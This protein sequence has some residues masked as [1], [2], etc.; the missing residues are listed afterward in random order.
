MEKYVD[1]HNCQNQ[2][3]CERTYLGGCTDGKEWENET[4]KAFVDG[5]EQRREELKA[6]RQAILEFEKDICKN[7]SPCALVDWVDC[8]KKADCGKVRNQAK[9]LYRLG[10]RKLSEGSVIITK[11]QKAEI[12]RLTEAKEDLYFQNQNLQTYID[13]HEPIWK[14]NT[15][16]AVKDTAREILKKV[17][18]YTLDKEVGMRY[19]LQRLA[20]EYGLEVE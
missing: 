17:K 9:V 3:D 16:Q 20:K 18:S 7:A 11:A 8:D 19:L 4:E 5:W 6:E 14:R 15:E 12:E 1:C 13:N 10:Y 2:Y